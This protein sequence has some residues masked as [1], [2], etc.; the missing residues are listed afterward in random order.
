MGQSWI[1]A[2]RKPVASTMNPPPALKSLTIEGMV[3]GKISFAQK[4]S[5]RKIVACGIATGDTVASGEQGKDHRRENIKYGLGDQDAV[6][7]AHAGD[8]CPVDAL[9]L[10]QNR[11]TVVTTLLFPI[12]RSNAFLFLRALDQYHIDLLRTKRRSKNADLDIERCAD[13]KERIKEQ[14]YHISSI[15]SCNDFLCCA[16]LIAMVVH[17]MTVIMQVAIEPLAIGHFVPKLFKIPVQLIYAVV[18]QIELI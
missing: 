11:T 3:S 6:V 8:D 7:T 5:T 1:F 16:L 10:A 17:H 13:L 9:P 15:R 14:V 2:K 12:T 18:A 4:K